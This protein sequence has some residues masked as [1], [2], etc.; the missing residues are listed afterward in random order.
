VCDQWQLVSLDQLPDLCRQGEGLNVSIVEDANVG[1]CILI[2]AVKS[3]E[4]CVCVSDYW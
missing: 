2:T 1:V 3:M 4:K